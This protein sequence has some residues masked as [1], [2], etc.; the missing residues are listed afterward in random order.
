ML[1]YKCCKGK[2]QKTDA[3][4]EHSDGINSPERNKTNKTQA[5][6]TNLCY[7]ILCALS[8]S[9]EAL[10]IACSRYIVYVVQRH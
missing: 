7:C 9:R 8:L 4:S 2:I 10:C 1:L 5:T 3:P 6:S